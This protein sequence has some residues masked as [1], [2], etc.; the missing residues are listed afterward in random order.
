MESFEVEILKPKAANIL[1]DLESMKLIRLKKRAVSA[2]PGKKV[3][4]VN[5]L[6][7][8][9]K[10]LKEVSLIQTGKIKPKS[11]KAILNEK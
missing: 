5:V 2:K 11:L 4:K 6:T 7:Q 1:Y 3:S 10:G 8:I 9:E